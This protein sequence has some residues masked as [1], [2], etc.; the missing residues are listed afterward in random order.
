[1]L[2]FIANDSDVSLLPLSPLSL[3]TGAI[4]CWRHHCFYRYCHYRSHYHWQWWQYFAAAVGL[5]TEEG[6]RPHKLEEVGKLDCLRQDVSI[7]NG[8]EKIRWLQRLLLWR[9]VSYAYYIFSFTPILVAGWITE[10][11]NMS[12][13]ASTLVETSFRIWIR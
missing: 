11:Q 12:L 2:C 13:T 1:M 6:G 3:Q 7:G 8:Q 5:L 10:A 4:V 9:L